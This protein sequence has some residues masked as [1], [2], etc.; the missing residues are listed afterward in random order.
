[1]DREIIIFGNTNNVHLN[2]A[3]ILFD[4]GYSAKIIGDF[5]PQDTYNVF[6]DWYGLDED[7]VLQDPRLNEQLFF[8]DQKALKKILEILVKDK[9]VI[10]S[11]W[12]PAI[13]HIAGLRIDMFLAMGH[14]ALAMPINSNGWKFSF[15][16]PPFTINS[17]LK[18]PKNKTNHLF[19]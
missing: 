14:D 15:F 17:I 1:M 4:M 2:I 11:G 19:L 9:F 18:N 12:W 10:A 3:K 13:F 7:V 6:S 16:N 5:K 8:Y